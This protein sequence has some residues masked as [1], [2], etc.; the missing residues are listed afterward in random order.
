MKLNINGKLIHTNTILTINTAAS[1]ITHLR[2]TVVSPGIYGTIYGIN[3]SI[4]RRKFLK[5]LRG[6]E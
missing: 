5:K 3:D 4:I 1:A 2:L 6:G